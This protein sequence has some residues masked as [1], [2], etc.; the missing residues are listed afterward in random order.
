VVG[1]VGH[2]SDVARQIPRTAQGLI[3]LESI[4][5]RSF[6]S[7]IAS[8]IWTLADLDPSIKNTR[9]ARLPDKFSTN[10]KL[11][12][13]HGRPR[14]AKLSFHDGLKEEIAAMHPDFDVRRMPACP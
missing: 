2:G 4:A 3:S 1:R 5:S 13:M 12:T 7:F 11:A 14:F 8:R 6:R 10:R 9:L